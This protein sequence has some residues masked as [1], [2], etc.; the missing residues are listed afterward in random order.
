MCRRFRTLC[1]IFIGGLVP[2]CLWRHFVW[3]LRIPVLM[4]RIQASGLLQWVVGWLIVQVLKAVYSIKLSG[5]DKAASQ[6]NNTEDLNLCHITQSVF[7]PTH[8]TGVHSVADLTSPLRVRRSCEVYGIQQHFLCR[9]HSSFASWNLSWKINM[10][11]KLP[12]KHVT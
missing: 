2:S 7:Q 12:E 3:D 8:L 10:Q 6:H 11:F 9:W 4:P 5:I 1:S